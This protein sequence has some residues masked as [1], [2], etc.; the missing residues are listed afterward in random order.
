MPDDFRSLD[1]AAIEEARQT[2]ES[3]RNLGEKALAIILAESLN[4]ALAALLENSMVPSSSGA[5]L[6]EF[7]AL[8]GFA[9]RIDASYAFG[10]IA[11]EERKELHLIRRIR[12]EFAHTTVRADTSFERAPVRNRCMELQ[13]VPELLDLERFDATRPSGR[14]VMSCSFL[15]LALY[16]RARRTRRCEVPPPITADDLHAARENPGREGS[17]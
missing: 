16:M 7:R 12:N 10:L 13:E 9:A 1:T 14:F 2:L 8:A 6:G 17:R 4:E 15:F 5:L 3:V 11:D